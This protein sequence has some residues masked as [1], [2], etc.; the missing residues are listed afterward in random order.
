M[1]KLILTFKEKILEAYPLTPDNKIS[2]G[3]DPSNTIVIDNLAVSGVHAEVSMDTNGPHLSDLNSKNG[4]FVNDCQVDHSNL[5]HKDTI[6]IGK[7]VLLVD[8][9]DEIDAPLAPERPATDQNTAGKEGL[10]KS[11][12]MHL[13]TS[14]GRQLRGEEP[15]PPEPVRPEKDLLNVVAGG[16]GE[17]DLGQMKRFSIGRNG[18]ADLVIGGIWGLFMGRPA[19]IISKQTGDYYLRYAGGL[20]KPKRNGNSINGTAILNHDDVVS[21]GPVQL[22]IQL[23]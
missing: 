5:T 19:A 14:H 1:S 12:T 6:I 17:Y 7:H 11:Q 16:E 8:L 22:Q 4:T 13:D 15:P 20:I 23:K 10:N 21:V 9:Q 18:D 2:I 3:R